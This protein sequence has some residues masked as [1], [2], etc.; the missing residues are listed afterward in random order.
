VILGGGSGGCS[1]AAKMA[2]KM[3]PAQIAVIEPSD[4]KKY[5]LML[6]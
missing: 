6:M 2:R 3:D 1:V 4:V 5:Y